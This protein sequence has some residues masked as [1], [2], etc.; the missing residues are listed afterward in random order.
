MLDQAYYSNSMTIPLPSPTDDSRRLVSVALWGLKQMYKAG[1]N[2]AKAGV[3]LGELVPAED[4]QTD[5]FARSNSI[6][7]TTLKTNKLMT[8]MDGINQKMGKESIKLAS[9]GFKRP[10]KMKQENKSPSYT[11][12]WE[13]TVRSY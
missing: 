9:E 7:N 12:K 3:M 13:E 6:S 8:V 4:C 11:T 1:F 2:Y 5:L 10:W